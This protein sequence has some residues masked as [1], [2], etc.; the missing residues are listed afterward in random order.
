MG[1]LVKKNHPAAENDNSRS[2][3]DA[4]FIPHLETTAATYKALLDILG[5]QDKPEKIRALAEKIEQVASN[6][7]R[8]YATNELIVELWKE[9]GPDKA[10]LIKPEDIHLMTSNWLDAYALNNSLKSQEFVT[11]F[12]LSHNVILERRTEEGAQTT[13]SPQFPLLKLEGPL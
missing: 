4:I 12:G 9:A 7:A 2:H 11:L 13:I 3:W 10:P 5:Y 6:D 8:L 1:K